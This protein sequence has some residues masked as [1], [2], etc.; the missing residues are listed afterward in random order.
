M[1][2]LPIE[3]WA[4]QWYGKESYSPSTRNTTE[5]RV[6]VDRMHGNRLRAEFYYWLGMRLS[7]CPRMRRDSPELRW[8]RE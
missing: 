6:I 8:M 4:G 3:E 7:G 1:T 5:M 2:H